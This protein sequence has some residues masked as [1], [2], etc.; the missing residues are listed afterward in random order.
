VLENSTLVARENRMQGIINS[1]VNKINFCSKNQ[2][3]MLVA[4]MIINLKEA[5]S[6][7]EGKVNIA[8]INRSSQ[9]DNTSHLMVV[10]KFTEKTQT[11][12]CQ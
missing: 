7:L 12:P 11:H 6:E 5:S 9:S 10:H 1:A 3:P 4:T 8:R 2:H